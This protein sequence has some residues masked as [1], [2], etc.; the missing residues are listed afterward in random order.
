M[1]EQTQTTEPTNQQT[2]QAKEQTTSK[3]TNKQQT[4]TQTN[5][6]KITQAIYDKV[7]P[8]AHHQIDHRHH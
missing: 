3:Q 2:A 8:D 5:N 7:V 4:A 1:S 6:P